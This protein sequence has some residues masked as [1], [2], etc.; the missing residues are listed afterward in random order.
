[1][2]FLNFCT[3]TQIQFFRNNLDHWYKLDIENSQLYI[4]LRL[5]ISVRKIYFMTDAQMAK[6]KQWIISR[7]IVK[8]LQQSRRSFKI[9][10][11]HIC[12]FPFVPRIQRFL[13]FLQFL[14]PVN[15]NNKIFGNIFNSTKVLFTSRCRRQNFRPSLLHLLVSK[16]YNKSFALFNSRWIVLYDA[17]I[18]RTRQ[19]TTTNKKVKQTVCSKKTSQLVKV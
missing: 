19:T 1:M 10:T 11:K 7:K 16:D 9:I 6:S 12:M 18:G 17:H 8:K 2:Y 13:Y 5:M 15:S 3:C 14:T 4:L